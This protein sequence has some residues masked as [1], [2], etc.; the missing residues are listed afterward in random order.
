MSTEKSWSGGL[1]RTRDG[2]GG[3]SIYFSGSAAVVDGGIAIAPGG[4][5]DGSGRWRTIGMSRCWR[6]RRWYD[7]RLAAPPECA[8]RDRTRQKISLKR[9]K[10]LCRSRLL[11]GE[12]PRGK[13]ALIIVMQRARMH[14]TQW[15]HDQ[16]GIHGS[17]GG[18]LCRPAVSR[19]SNQPNHH[20]RQGTKNV[21]GRQH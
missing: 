7:R 5:G 14:M 13:P 6:D 21:N 8:E 10:Y 15:S 1:F 20:R 19:T 16:M 9:E 2:G 18:G 11:D 4:R 3:S 12:C 17:V